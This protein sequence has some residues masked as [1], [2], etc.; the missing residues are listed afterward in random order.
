MCTQLGEK[1]VTG[2]RKSLE[3]ICGYF[4]LYGKD[5][6]EAPAVTKKLGEKVEMNNAI[7]KK[8]Y[9]CGGALTSTDAIIEVIKEEGLS[10]EDIVSVDIKVSSLVYKVVGQQFEVR[11][12]P[13]YPG[14]SGD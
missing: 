12:T 7:V 10:R 9:N 13:R 4:H 3:G 5:K 6:Y 2:G 14:K 11:D 8:Y 1:G